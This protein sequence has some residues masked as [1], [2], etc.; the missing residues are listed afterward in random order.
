[1]PPAREPAQEQLPLF[2]LNHGI[3]VN[4]SSRGW[5]RSGRL[6]TGRGRGRRLERLPRVHGG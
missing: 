1:M 2:C 4:R 3:A 6:V 5:F